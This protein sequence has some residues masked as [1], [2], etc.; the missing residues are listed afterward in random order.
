MTEDE[1]VGIEWRSPSSMNPRVMFDI[2][3]GSS[4]AVDL[5]VDK[6]RDIT[7]VLILSLSI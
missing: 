5:D 2:F 4:I 7:C 3:T 1:T 6:F